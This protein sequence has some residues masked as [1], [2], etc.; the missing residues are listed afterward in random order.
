M[1]IAVGGLREG[2]ERVA[3]AVVRIEL[4][5]NLQTSGTVLLKSTGRLFGNVQAANFVVESG[6][7]FVGDV[8]IGPAAAAEL[9]KDARRVMTR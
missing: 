2:E 9:K 5:A 1:F 3:L 7:I 8:K 6:A 4:A